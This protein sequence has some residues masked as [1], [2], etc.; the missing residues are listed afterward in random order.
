[1]LYNRNEIL[2]VLGCLCKDLRKLKDKKYDLKLSDFDNSF[3]KIIFGVL[4]NISLEKDISEVNGALIA[5]YLEKFPSQ[6]LRFDE[7]K[8]LEFIDAIKAKSENSSFDYSYR[9]V[10]KFSLL[11]RYKEIGMDIK[12]I[13]N[14][15]LLYPKEIEEREKRFEKMTLDEIKYHFKAKMLEIDR[16]FQTKTD[17]Y[18][19]DLSE[20][21]E[22]MIEEYKAGKAW[23]TPYQCGFFNTI[24]R[25]QCSSKFFLRSASTAGGKSRQAIGDM[26]LTSCPERYD[27]FT[28]TWIQNNKI[29]ASML[30]STE[31]IGV[32]I[33]TTMLAAIAAV[34]EETIKEGKMS[35]EEE[36]RVKRAMRSLENSLMY[37]E[38]DSNF[39]ISS[40][41]AIIEKHIIINNVNHIYFDYIQITNN[42]SK[43]INT[44]FGYTLREDQMLNFLSSS[45]KSWANKYNIYIASS[46]QLNKT[47]KTDENIDVTML[48]GGAST[49]DKC[50]TVV[51]TMKVDADTRAKIKPILDEKFGVEPTHVHHIC[52][53]RGGKWNGIL[54]WVSMDLDIIHVKDCFATTKD[55]I[56]I[57][58][59]HP[60]VI[61]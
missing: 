32:E 56:L 40:L 13:Y 5:T 52:K 28:K 30:I 15:N 44:L 55:Y 50:D 11:R 21:L 10:K 49:A 7:Y 53:N 36:V 16:E 47:Y 17:S 2:N 3:H 60:T 37:C 39:S 19:I 61:F 35:E 27:P 20:N 51:I 29:E 6:K 57:E 14:E 38:Y 4:L 45:L 23:G 34:P 26:I 54:I 31:L 41:E 46:T 42:L 48:R 22:E 59:L 8:G 12:E 1:M 43:E 18:S 33:K 25:G 58:K 9:V 24:F